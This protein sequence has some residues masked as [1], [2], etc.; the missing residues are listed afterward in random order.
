MLKV[1]GGKIP[2]NSQI[3]QQKCWDM[4]LLKRPA[5]ANYEHIYFHLAFHSPDLFHPDIAIATRINT[6]LRPILQPLEDLIIFLFCFYT[7]LLEHDIS[8]I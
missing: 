1:L 5:L 2:K 3:T 6:V 4:W 7:K 8:G